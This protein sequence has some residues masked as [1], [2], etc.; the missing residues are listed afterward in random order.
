MAVAHTHSC[1]TAATFPRA[2]WAQ[3]EGLLQSWKSLLQGLP[4]FTACDL[5]LRRTGEGDV[6]CTI[7]V[8]FEHE[9]QLDEFMR[10]RWAPD[11]MFETLD[12]KPYDVVADHL[13]PQS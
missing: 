9:E 8:A 12:P 5:W 4:G 1:F 2:T 7:H 10:C 3:A 11:A 6:R 13:E